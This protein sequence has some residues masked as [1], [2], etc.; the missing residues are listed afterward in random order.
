MLSAMGLFNAR[1]YDAL[2]AV[3]WL[4][5]GSNHLRR[6]FVD[7]LDIRREH[8]VLEFGCGTGQITRQLLLTGADVT[9]VDREP[10]ML[11]RARERAPG[12]HYVLDDVLAAEVEGRFDRVVFGFVLHELEPETRIELLTTG[13]ERLTPDGFVGILEWSVPAKPALAKVW[14]PIVRAIE[15][16][17]AH[18]ILDGGLETALEK[19]GL[20]VTERRPLVGGRARVVLARPS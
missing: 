2:N 10:F 12:A 11:T 16:A 13:A 15:P 18:D 6:Q 17:V 19:S 9:A 4:P 5:T 3:L 14:K 8:C 1:T 7:A 20:V